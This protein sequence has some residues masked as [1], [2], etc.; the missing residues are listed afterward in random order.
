MLFQDALVS[1]IGISGILYMYAKVSSC[2]S[3]CI[4]DNF[5]SECKVVEVGCSEECQASCL[6]LLLMV[7]KRLPHV[8]AEFDEIGGVELIQ[9]VLRT[10]QAAVGYKIADVC[11]VCM[12]C[13]CMC[14]R[15]SNSPFFILSAF[16]M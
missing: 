6:Q 12:L 8:R 16:S 13:A 11:V 3:A 15:A 9:Q 5:V 1:A 7:M 4:V 2:A 10:P 14:V